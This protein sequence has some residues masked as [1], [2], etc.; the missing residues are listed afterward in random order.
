MVLGM[1]TLRRFVDRVV[2][3]YEQ[4][5]D[6]VSIGQY[7]RQWRKWAVAGIR[8]LARDEYDFFRADIK[9]AGAVMPPT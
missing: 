9:K 7:V 1:G 8:S 4:D 3:L 2:R 6:L 5:A